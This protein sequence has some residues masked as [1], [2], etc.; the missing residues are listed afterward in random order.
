[1]HCKRLSLLLPVRWRA[2]AERAAFLPAPPLHMHAC[3]ALQWAIACRVQERDTASG[4]ER[5]APAGAHTW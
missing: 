5:L 4:M 2:S 1:M 3:A